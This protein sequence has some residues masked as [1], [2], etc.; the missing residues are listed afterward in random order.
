MRYVPGLHGALVMISRYAHP[1]FH[2]SAMHPLCGG[3]SHYAIEPW[4]ASVAKDTCMQLRVQP[5]ITFMA[6]V[7]PGILPLNRS[8]HRV[9]E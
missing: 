3:L 1:F 6:K 7:L 8:D 4:H 9:K 5:K 2:H